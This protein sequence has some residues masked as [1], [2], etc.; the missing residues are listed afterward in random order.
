[1]EN[2]SMELDLRNWSPSIFMAI[3]SII[4]IWKEGGEDDFQF[5]N[6]SLLSSIFNVIPQ[7]LHTNMWMET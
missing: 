3:M 2:F 1:M 4:Q 7:N 5:F 6:I